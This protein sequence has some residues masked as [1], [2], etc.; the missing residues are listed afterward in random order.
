MTPLPSGI[1]LHRAES[2]DEIPSRTLYRIARLRQEVFV[3]EQNCVYLDLDG[4]DL[5]P[6]SIQIWAATPDGTIA[7][8]L[9]ILSEDALEPGLRSIGRVVTDPAWRGRGI[10]AAVL[11]SAIEAC[12][13]HPILIHAQ[14]HLTEW[15]ARFGFV[16]SGPEFLEDDIPHTPMRLSGG[17]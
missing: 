9:R 8:S 17:A 13:E 5:D 10:A 16:T 7:S 14:S 11:R 12:A 4:R 6:G 1:T 3:V 2:L 15:Y